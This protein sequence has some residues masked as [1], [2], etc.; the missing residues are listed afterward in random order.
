MAMFGPKWWHHHGSKMRVKEFCSGQKTL[1]LAGSAATVQ[2]MP[3]PIEG[4][5]PEPWGVEWEVKQSRNEKANGRVFMNDKQLAG[6]FG[7]AEYRDE[8]SQSILRDFPAECAHQGK[9]IRQGEY[10]N[11]PGPGT[12]HDGDPNASIQINGEIKAAVGAL[13]GLNPQ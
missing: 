8:L 7:L 12:G 2:I 4:Q 11:I 3:W 6:A 13:L 1:V 5:K 10:L 9:F